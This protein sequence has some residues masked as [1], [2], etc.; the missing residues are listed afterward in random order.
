[1][2]VLLTETSQDQIRVSEYHPV[3]T[4]S[5]Y[6]EVGRQRFRSSVGDR[7]IGR[8]GSYDGCDHGQSAILER[9]AAQ[10]DLV[11][12][13]IYIGTGSHLRDPA[14]EC[15]P[16]RRGRADAQLAHLDAVPPEQLGG[17]E[18]PIALLIGGAVSLLLICG[19]VN[20][21]RMGNQTAE[22]AGANG[23]DQFA[24]AL[25]GGLAWQ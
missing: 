9:L 16:G 14:A 4:Q 10:S 15:Q 13:A 12:I 21:P 19:C 8:R 24:H 3:A 17:D 1:D 2:R 23:L 5:G 20:K 18:Q 11:R 6:S 7:T 25:G 22:A